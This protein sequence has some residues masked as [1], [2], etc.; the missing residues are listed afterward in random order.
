LGT[1]TWRYA[2]YDFSEEM[3]MCLLL[4]AVYGVVRGTGRWI[5]AG[6][7]GFALLLLVKLVYIAFLPI[8][9]VWLISL[10]V[11]WRDRIRSAALFVV[12]VGVSGGVLAWMNVVR[13]GNPFES[14]YGGEAHQFFPGQLW[15]TIPQL[16]VSLDKGLLVYCPVLILGVFGW[17][18]FLAGHRRAAILCGAITV[19]NLL[20]AGMWHSWEGGWSAGPR[21]LVPAIPFWLLPA[22]IWLNRLRSRAIFGAF[23]VL[24]LISIAVQV[25]DV[26]V[27]DQEVHQ[28]KE[29]LLTP[30]EQ[31]S[32][33]SNSVATWI[34][35]WHKLTVQGEVYRLS[36]LH[37]PGNR[38]LDLT[39][40]RT[41]AGVNVW[42]EHLARQMHKPVLRWLPLAAILLIFYQLFQFGLTLKGAANTQGFGWA[43]RIQESRA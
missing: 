40:F 23:I 21:L 4:L 31:L 18:A 8:F 39:Q 19:G 41:M 25:P 27:K 6:G 3:Q 42:T 10:P 32:A 5:A 13:F 28:I 17:R 12:P 2:A 43:E 36:E 34:I 20:L 24:M 14:G 30:Q 33:P 7:V 37:I 1:L 35:L 38:E 26:L 11:D 9:A 29:K 15:H 22:A 16:L